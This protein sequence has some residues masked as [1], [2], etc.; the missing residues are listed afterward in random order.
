MIERTVSPKGFRAHCD[1]N[2]CT[3]SDYISV[4]GTFENAIDEMIRKGWLNKKRKH[5]SI[6]LCPDC[7]DLFDIMETEPKKAIVVKIKK[8]DVFL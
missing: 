4:I 8:K 1:S 7:K 3:Y 2:G 6:H 5:D